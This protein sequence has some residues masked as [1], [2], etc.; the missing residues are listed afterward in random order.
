QHFCLARGRH[1]GSRSRPAVGRVSQ[2]CSG[3]SERPT[4]EA[5]PTGREQSAARPRLETSGLGPGIETGSQQ[6]NAYSC[7]CT[8]TIVSGFGGT[9]TTIP[10]PS[11][12]CVAGNVT[13]NL[14]GG[15]LTADDLDND[16]RGRVKLFYEDVLRTC[17]LGNSPLCECGPTSPA[18]FDQAC[19]GTCE[20]IR[21]QQSCT[22][23]NDRR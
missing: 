7:G 11:D 20:S 19:D 15:L 4:V 3:Q 10:V 13:P 14:H 21:A 6:P 18:F 9:Q 1:R 23:V 17:Y 8:C 22:N 5:A 16:C 12:V 2:H